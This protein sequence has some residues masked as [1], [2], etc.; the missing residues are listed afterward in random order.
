MSAYYRT[1]LAG[2]DSSNYFIFLANTE[3]IGANTEISLTFQGDA[4]TSFEVYW[5]DGSSN[6][7]T[8]T[9]TADTITHDYGNVGLRQIKITGNMGHMVNPNANNSQIVELRNYGSN[10][11]LIA[12]QSNTFANA[13]IMTITAYNYPTFIANTNCENYFNNCSSITAT[14]TNSWPSST[15]GNIINMNN[16]FKGCNNFIGTDIENWNTINVT[17]LAGC[18]RDATIFNANISSW[19]VSNVTKM[20]NMFESAGNFNYDLDQW[21]TT[22]VTDMGGMF[23]NTSSF[24]GNISTWNTS[25]VTTMSAMFQSAPNFNS[26]I[27]A[28]NV[29][30]VTNMSIMFQS[31]TNFNSNIGA[32]NVSNVTNMNSMFNNTD[33]FNHDLDQWDTSKVT[34]MD[35]MFGSNPVFN[36][37]ISTW[38]TGNVTSMERMF[39]SAGIN[40][41]LGNWNIGSINN[42][43]GMLENS[44]M[45][46]E[47]YSKT[48]IGWAN[49][50][51][52]NSGTPAN[53]TLGADT[54]TY[55]NVTY[56]GSPYSDAVSARSYLTGTAGWTITDG[57]QV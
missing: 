16:M 5:G 57:G 24:N 46:T 34:N 27:S 55:S 1:I 6:L 22:N 9:G 23:N 7:I 19:N 31:A 8:H 33:N 48:L 12:N 53:I 20:N 36:G 38:N 37:N 44:S 43:V 32:W 15:T 41:N 2:A 25:N 54:L 11:N 51:S 4:N 30:N 56:T 29:T 10:V 40:Q 35:Y 49:Y 14:S 28:W 52:N 3:S 26:N 47:N 17:T 39:T 50:V 45:S 21:N 18:F 13:N 42:M